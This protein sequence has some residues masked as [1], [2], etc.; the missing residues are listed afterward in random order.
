MSKK[1]LYNVDIRW[2]DEDQVFIARVP[3]LA[4]VVTHGDSVVEAA[5][6]AEEAIAL[7]LKS[8]VEGSL[9]LCRALQYSF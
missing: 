5:K 2:S 8:Q 7:Y 6:M 3:E 9:H 4:G 1:Y